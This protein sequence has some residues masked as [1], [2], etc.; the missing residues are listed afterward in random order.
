MSAVIV[1]LAAEAM[2]RLWVPQQT[3]WPV[4]NIYQPSDVPGLHYTYRPDFEG[5]AF[6]V[7]L[8][9]NSLG[10]R[11]AEWA[12]EKAAGTLRIALIG[13]S[14]AFGF[15]VPSADIIPQVLSRR[16]EDRYGVP[17]E[18]LNFGVNGYN[19]AQQLAALEHLALDYR[20]DLVLVL[21]A[22]NDHKPSLRADS[23]GWLHWDGE[24]SNEGSRMVD[25]AIEEVVATDVSWWMDKSRLVLY[26]KL[27]EKRRR[28][29]GQAHVQRRTESGQFTVDEELMGPPDPWM[30]F[31]PPGPVALRLQETVYDPLVKGM[32][33]IEERGLPIVLATFCSSPDY[34]QMFQILEEE[35]GVTL[36]ELF[37]LFPEAGSWDELTAQF[38]LGWDA[39]LNAVAHRRFAEAIDAAIAEGDLLRQ[40]LE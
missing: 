11:G 4:S 31:F 10:F 24:G 27:L 8:R 34:R 22:N 35:R 16:L 26:L 39:H 21:P 33:R 6:G 32:D 1:A 28:F 3:F 19:G 25:R 18:V 29:A 17:T 38:G 2:V 30:G 36:I 7:D 20:P 23:E 12:K 14:H 37:E 40:A 13:D 15:G 5:V 9:T